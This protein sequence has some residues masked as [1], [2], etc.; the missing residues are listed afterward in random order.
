MTGI[1]F[2]GSPR[3]GHPTVD[4]L[5]SVGPEEVEAMTPKLDASLNCEARPNKSPFGCARVALFRVC[6]SF[7]AFLVLAVP[8]SRF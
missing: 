4:P 3:E 1:S 5:W 6:C 8:L 2:R 7:V